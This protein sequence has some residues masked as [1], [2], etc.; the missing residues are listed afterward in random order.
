MIPLH[1][2]IGKCYYAVECKNQSC[3]HQMYVAEAGS[4]HS[5]AD[6]DHLYGQFV[7]CPMCTQESPIEDRRIV[8]IG[9]R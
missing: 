6:I 2:E 1:G 8:V 9:V 4:N 7:R 3:R 5:R